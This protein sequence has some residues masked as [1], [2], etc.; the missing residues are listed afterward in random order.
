MADIALATASKVEVVESIEQMTLPAAEAITAG[1]PVR[2]DTNGKFTNANGT[3][4]AE[5]SVYGIATKTAPAGFGLTAIRRGVLDGF[6]FSGAYNVAVYLSDTDGRLA[7]AAGTVAARIGWI[8]PAWSQALGTAADKL[9]LVD[10]GLAAQDVSNAAERLVV[11]SELL[12]ASVD[13]WMFVADRAYRV[14]AVR[15]VHNVVGGLGAVVRPRKVTSAGTAAPGDAA[16]ATVKELTAADVDLT[17]TI[18]VVQSPAL[19]A[20]AADLDLAAGDKIGLN[21][22]GTLTG[23]VGV[24][25]IALMAI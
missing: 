16:G 14:M 25:E 10:C 20:T 18:N 7:D 24:I 15:E 5:A 11:T 3:T 13:K 6:T 19:S 8:I 2:I 4:S 17:T 23:L 22:S 9:L 12:A 1:A 21:F